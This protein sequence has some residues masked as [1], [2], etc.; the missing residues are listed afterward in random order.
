MRIIICENYEE[1]SQK[2]AAIMASQ[3]ILKPD[4]VLGLATGST[5]I[6]MYEMLAEMNQKG[7]IDFEKVKSFNLDEYYKIAP[8]NDQS[9]YYFMN[10]K[11]FSKVNIKTENTHILD[12]LA[13][14]PEAECAR[15][16][17]LIEESG[18]I[19]MQLLG[20]G[21]NGH[22]GFNEPDET[23]CAVT[24]LTG[25]TESTINANSVFFES[26]DEM[27]KSALTMGIGSILKSKRI[28][29]L[30]NGESKRRA[31]AELM[32]NDIKTSVPASL[33]K[34]HPD[35]ILLCDKAA[36]ADINLEESGVYNG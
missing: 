7:E 19:D 21:Q 24:H 17:K 28:M 2:A 10:D 35:V 8:D 4:S 6:R 30:A 33:L 23:L 20:I 22:I 31:V 26:K 1:M 12:G 15:F 36:C 27:P 3:L 29:L 5:P 16:E 25:L 32:N 11:L 14:D 13:E 18:G 34:T 9:Y